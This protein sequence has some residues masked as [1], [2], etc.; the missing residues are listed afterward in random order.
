MKCEVCGKKAKSKCSKCQNVGYCGSVCQKLDWKSHKLECKELNA[1]SPANT[2]GNSATVKTPVTLV[3]SDIAETAYIMTDKVYPVEND[4]ILEELAIGQN[5]VVSRKNWLKIHKSTAT[6]AAADEVQCLLL[7]EEGRALYEQ[8]RLSAASTKWFEALSAIN[9]AASPFDVSKLPCRTA[10]ILWGNIALCLMSDEEAIRSDTK[11]TRVIVSMAASACQFT[12]CLDP[13]YEKWVARRSKFES[14]SP[15]GDLEIIPHLKSAYD[16]WKQLESNFTVLPADYVCRDHF[17]AI[18][19]TFRHASLIAE[20]IFRLYQDA[21]EERMWDLVKEQSASAGTPAVVHCRASL[22]SPRGDL[23]CLTISMDFA[24]TSST[25]ALTKFTL[26]NVAFLDI[27]DTGGDNLFGPDDGRAS[28][29]TP[30]AKAA[31]NDAISE[32]VEKAHQEHGV[33]VLSV[34]VGQGLLE[35]SSEEEFKRP[36]RWRGAMVHADMKWAMKD[37]MKAGMDAAFPGMSMP[38]G[39]AGNGAPPGCPTS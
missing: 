25:G 38:S 36:G 29:S 34:L 9:M 19:M 14:L 16:Y 37:M 23:V 6:A 2:K 28:V 33:K 18:H 22:V 3:D 13:S 8:G 7:K 20:D 17:Y 32:F 15:R 11:K 31:A 26:D 10:A 24:T 21:R 30:K 1:N 4:D 12:Q 27:D 5:H 39:G 35:L